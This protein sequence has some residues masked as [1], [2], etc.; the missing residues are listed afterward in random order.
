[1]IR[2][3]K[4]KDI[5]FEKYESCFKNSEQ[6]K[7]SASKE[8][9]DIVTD[10]KWDLLV[11]NDYEAVMPVPY[12][13]KFLV[14]I[15]TRPKLC[16]QLGVFSIK[17]SKQLNEQFFEF[18]NKKYF[19]LKHYSFNA[20]NEIS[21]NLQPRKNYYINKSDFNSVSKNYSPKR[22]RKISLGYEKIENL[23]IVSNSDLDET[24]KQFI[25]KY[26]KGID[27]SK[28]IWEYISLFQEFSSKGLMYFLKLYS[29]NQLINL[30]A[31]YKDEET[32]ALLGTFNDPNYVKLN[33][34][35][36]LIDK[37]IKDNIHLY[38]FDFEGSELPSVDEFFRGFGPQKEMYSILWKNYK[39]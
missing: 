34:A 33:G 17:D 18:L 4:Y 36:V 23:N 16:Q 39:L 24:T 1:M 11:Y 31:L 14:K 5:D 15:V 32:V 26:F 10:K 3:V 25:H 22:R 20:K 9:L 6:R 8:F 28:T 30:L 13:N 21:K 37:A 38:N 29:N 27:S 12:H 2:R 35:S 19:F 7:Y